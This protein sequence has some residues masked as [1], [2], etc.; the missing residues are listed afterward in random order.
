MRAHV[1]A[2]VRA[3]DGSMTVL[4]R[5][6]AQLSTDPPTPHHSTTARPHPGSTTARPSTPPTPPREPHI[7]LLNSHVSS[8]T[9]TAAPAPPHSHQSPLLR[10]STKYT[11]PTSQRCPPHA[12]SHGSP[13]LT[14]THPA[15]PRQLPN[16]LTNTTQASQASHTTS[17]K[18]QTKIPPSRTATPAPKPQSGVLHGTSNSE[19]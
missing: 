5:R 10:Q 3:R 15:R 16:H 18:S 4:A 9:S 14:R 12:H 8:C 2:C 11:T 1:R 17:T 6:G 7:L 13:T 19:R